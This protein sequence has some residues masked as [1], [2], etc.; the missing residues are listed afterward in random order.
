M[1]RE[2]YARSFRPRPDRRAGLV[3]LLA[4]GLVACPQTSGL[5][6]GPDATPEPTPEPPGCTAADSPRIEWLLP[7]PDGTTTLFEPVPTR[8]RVCDFEGDP[9]ALMFETS[10]DFGMTWTPGTWEGL[11][12][13]NSVMIPTVAGGAWVEQTGS[14]ALPEGLPERGMLWIG[15]QL[16]ARVQDPGYDFAIW[17]SGT[18]GAAG[19]GQPVGYLLDTT[20]QDLSPPPAFAAGSDPL[21]VAW[22]KGSEL[23]LRADAMLDGRRYSLK[24]QTPNCDDGAV[25]QIGTDP[26]LAVVT[27]WDARVD[28]SDIMPTQHRIMTLKGYSRLWVAESGRVT[29]TRCGLPGPGPIVTIDGGSDGGTVTLEARRIDGNFGRFWDVVGGAAASMPAQ[30][31]TAE[32]REYTWG[33]P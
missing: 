24:I 1:R 26:R 31:I 10:H 5:P 14:W 6:P 21:P 2:Q 25:Y 13:G 15:G 4:V 19:D 29:T 30:T 33:Y 11:Q 18:T 23:H 27:L 12:A 16:R 28:V 22:R 32:Q 17:E 9:L 7:L 20:S 3:A 8:V